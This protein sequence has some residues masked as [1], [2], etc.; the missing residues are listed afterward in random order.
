LLEVVRLQSD[1]FPRERGVRF[2]LAA[3]AIFY[4]VVW[5]AAPALV[6]DAPSLDIAEGYIWGIEW[7][8]GYYKHPPLSPWLTAASTTLFGRNLWAVFVLSPLVTVGCFVALWVLARQFLDERLSLVSVYLASTQLYLNLLIPEFNHN[9]MQTPL[10]AGA[11]AAA[12]FAF[13]GPGLAAWGVLG[14]ILGFCVLAKYSAAL[15]IATLGAIALLHPQ[16][17]GNLSL[18]RILVG[19][20]AALLVAGSNL[21]WQVAHDFPAM[22]Y[23]GDR[24]GAADSVSG[25][26]RNAAS[27][28]GAQVVAMLPILLVAVWGIRKNTRPNLGKWCEIGGGPS[29]AYLWASALLPFAVSVF[30]ILLTGKAFKSMWGTMMFSTLAL[31]LVA[32]RPGAF[33]GLFSRRAWIMWLAFQCLMLLTYAVMMRWGPVYQHKVSKALF[34]ATALA[35]QLDR[36]WSAQTGGAPL[37]YVIGD[38]WTGGVI[39]FS[40]PSAPSVMIDADPAKSPWVSEDRLRDCGALMVWAADRPTPEWFGPAAGGASQQTVRASVDGHPDLEVTLG[41]A[42]RR[43]D[44]ECPPQ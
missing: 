18:T 16:F 31:A 42:I 2:A 34:P 8:A 10:W 24:L 11:F 29:R 23:L 41:F 14:A 17:R 44:G 21:V 26:L 13:N 39:A 38:T 9:T 1:L 6:H 12:W 3:L 20:G 19:A 35:A 5:T 7:Q 15:L 40:L 36:A 32:W 4:V 22:H 27:F 33:A 25:H 28:F 30:A 43:P 37:R